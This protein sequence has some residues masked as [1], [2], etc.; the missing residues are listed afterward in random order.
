MEACSEYFCQTLKLVAPKY[1]PIKYITI[2]VNKIWSNVK[3]RQQDDKYE[4]KIY[5]GESF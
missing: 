3:T 2:T 5:K 1:L 4:G